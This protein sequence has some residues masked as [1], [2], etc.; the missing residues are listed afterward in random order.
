MMIGQI[1]ATSHDLGPQK[2]ANDGMG[3]PHI[4]GTSRLVKYDNLARMFIRGTLPPHDSL[5]IRVIF[6]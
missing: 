6:H 3:T 4:S 5:L 2:V 1:I